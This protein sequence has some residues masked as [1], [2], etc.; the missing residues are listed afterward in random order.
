MDYKNF[1]KD[2]LFNLNIHELRRLGAS[3]GVKSPSNQSKDNLVDNI[4]SIITGSQEPYKQKDRR[5][6]PPK[7]DVTPISLEM[8]ESR[9]NAL[10]VGLGMVATQMPQYNNYCFM[11]PENANA[12]RGTVVVRE[13]GMFIAKFPFVVSADDAMVPKDLALDFNLRQFDVVE[14]LYVDDNAYIK[15]VGKILTVNG[16]EVAPEE[17]VFNRLEADGKGEEVSATFNGEKINFNRG[18]KVLIRR[19]QPVTDIKIALDLAESIAKTGDVVIKLLIDKKDTIK[20]DAFTFE[21]LVTD[22]S[23]VVVSAANAAMLKAKALVGVGKSVV[24]VIDDFCSLNAAFAK[25]YGAEAETFVK[26]YLFSAEHFDNGA[27]LTI[28][29]LT[30]NKTCDKYSSYFDKTI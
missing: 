11:R 23:S 29:G 12:K 15:Q 24:I 14:F 30:S 13:T 8:L 7:G 4:Y 21:A 17:V 10:P 26:R 1:S 27:S 28:F 18:S 20:G 2:S 3:V 5:G 22:M 19:D 6:R 9:Q 16:K 25:I